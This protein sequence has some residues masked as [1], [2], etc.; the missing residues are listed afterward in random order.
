MRSYESKS[1]FVLRSFYCSMNVL[2]AVRLPIF[3]HR[4]SC[5]LTSTFRAW[6]YL[7]GFQEY[8]SRTDPFGKRSTSLY[9]K[10]TY[11]AR[12]LPERSS[13]NTEFCYKGTMPRFRSQFPRSTQGTPQDHDSPFDD[14]NGFAFFDSG[15]P[16]EAWVTRN[17]FLK[18]LQK[19]LLYLRMA[20]DSGARRAPFF[21]W[22][23]LRRYFF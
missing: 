4:L 7:A 12:Y 23:P 13:Q 1:V 10:G 21:A 11:K 8:N 5:Y 6:A 22:D 14:K 15:F 20:I 18:R 9:A 3:C 17:Q 2:H 19:F 16:A